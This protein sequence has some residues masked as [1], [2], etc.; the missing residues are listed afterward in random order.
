MIDCLYDCFKHWA[1]NGSVYI[2]SDPHF[3]DADCKTMDRNWI[4]PDEHVTMINRKIHKNDTLILLGDLGDPEYVKKI[5]AQKV[6]ITGN[7]DKPGMYKDVISE[8]Y[9]G[10]LAIAPKIILSHEPVNGL[11]FACNIHGHDHAGRHR[12]YDE[13]GAK[14]INVASNV[15]KWMPINLGEEIKAGLFSNIPDIH[16]VTIDYATKNSVK[17][18][19]KEQRK[20]EGEFVAG[21]MRGAKNVKI[22]DKKPKQPTQKPL[23]AEETN[24]KRTNKLRERYCL[25]CTNT[26]VKDL[27]ALMRGECPMYNRKCYVIV[28]STLEKP[29]RY[30]MAVGNNP[31]MEGCM[32]EFYEHYE[33][34]DG[35][36]F[37]HCT[38]CP[39][40]VAVISSISK[41]KEA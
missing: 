1:A 7:H 35:D 39:E 18:K 12:Y 10:I 40:M 14:H 13:A 25:N 17:K 31:D 23:T 24:A 36:K 26:D 5:K 16:R 15:C 4:D 20:R 22:H 6:L 28:N 30:V 33:K 9:D 37:I 19:N 21:S 3:R 11:I 32:E 2:L 34:I 29:V 41:S 38:S 27:D 8:Q